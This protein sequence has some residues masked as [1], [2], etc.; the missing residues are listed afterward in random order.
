MAAPGLA[1][2]ARGLRKSFGGKTVLDGIDLSVPAGTILALLGPNGAGKTTAVHL[3]TT[4]LRPEAGDIRIAGHDLAEDPQAVRRA[5]GVTGQ[6][7][8][9]DG[10]MVGVTVVTLAAV[11]VGFRPHA[12]VPEW[13]AAAGVVLLLSSPSTNPSPR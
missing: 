11:A 2:S 8:A 7:S 4:Y 3:L 5:I 9:V 13:F 6:F 10:T 12:G 1:I